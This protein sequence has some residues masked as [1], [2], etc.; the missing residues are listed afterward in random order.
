MEYDEGVTAQTEVMASTEIMCSLKRSV[1]IGIDGKGD[2][3]N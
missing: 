1:T 2:V 3:T